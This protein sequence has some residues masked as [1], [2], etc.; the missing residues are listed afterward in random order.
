VN[1]NI[2]PRGMINALK[3]L[4]ADQD[5]LKLNK[6]ELRGFSSHPPTEERMADL[7]DTADY[8]KGK[9]EL[10][11]SEGREEWEAVIRPYQAM[12]LQEQI[13]LNDPGASLYLLENLAKDGWFVGY[14]T[15]LACAV[16][17]GYDDP[18]P[19]G[20]G[21]AGAA[22]HSTGGTRRPA[23][24]ARLRAAEGGQQVEAN[25]VLNRYLAM[26]PDARMPP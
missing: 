19:M 6:L 21:E 11:G 13:Y 16:W 15:D 2:D 24:R 8:P 4:K 20:A 14:S 3:A 7:A 1:A 9:G 23:W 17:T 12:L 22:A 26:K 10:P 5:K 25:K 18:T